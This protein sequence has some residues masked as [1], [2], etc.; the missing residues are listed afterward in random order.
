ME[1]A[2]WA[3]MKGDPGCRGMTEGEEWDGETKRKR[4][5]GGGGSEVVRVSSMHR[6]PPTTCFALPC[7]CSAGI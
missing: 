7:A 1:E 3:F 5:Y 2:D 6:H 4:T